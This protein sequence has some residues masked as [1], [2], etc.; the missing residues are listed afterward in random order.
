MVEKSASM[1]NSTFLSEWRKHVYALLRV[2][3][4]LKAQLRHPP[5]FAIVGRNAALVT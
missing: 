2:R 5:H 1:G 3:R 4:G